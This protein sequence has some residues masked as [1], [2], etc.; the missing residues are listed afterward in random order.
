V[1][2][3]KISHPTGKHWIAMLVGVEIAE[4]MDSL[5]HKPPQDFINFLGPNYT[6]CSQRLQS[7]TYPSCGYYCL[8]YAVCRSQNLPFDRIVQDMYM[9]GDNSIMCTVQQIKP[10][11]VDIS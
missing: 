5:G 6:Y 4:Y 9:T 11:D 1:N 7:L 8:Y 3:A 2:T 10:I